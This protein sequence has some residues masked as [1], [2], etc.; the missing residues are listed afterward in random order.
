MKRIIFNI[1]MVIL[2]LT[3]GISLFYLFMMIALTGKLFPSGIKAVHIIFIVLLLIS[4]T[5]S[6]VLKIKLKNEK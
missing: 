6:I 5:S 4:L 3:L 2:A 1:S